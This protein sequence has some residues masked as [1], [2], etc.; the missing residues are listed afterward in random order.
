MF[1]GTYGL[2][3]GIYCN[4]LYILTNALG[5]FVTNSQ[6]KKGFRDF[7]GGFCVIV[8][9]IGVILRKFYICME[10]LDKYGQILTFMGLLKKIL[11]PLVVRERKLSAIRTSSL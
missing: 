7:F 10:K 5:F 8:C 1:I 2:W 11:A 6:Q 3:V 9:L 4:I